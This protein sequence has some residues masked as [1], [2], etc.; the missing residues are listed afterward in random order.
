MA[1]AVRKLAKQQGKKENA[2][3]GNYYN[4]RRKLEGSNRAPSRRA[5]PAKA[6]S[7]DDAVAEARRIL[8]QAHSAIDQEVDAAKRELDAAKSHYDVLIKSVNQR[9]AELQRKIAAL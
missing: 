4:H 1:D 8:E 2:V 9:K 5:R 3:R 6:T 7:V